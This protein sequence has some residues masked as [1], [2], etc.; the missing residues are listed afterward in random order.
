MK[1]ARYGWIR[2]LPDPRDAVLSDP[3]P[4]DGS[5]G[6]SVDLRAD[7][8]AA[9]DQGDLAACTANALASL[10]EFRSPLTGRLLEWMPSR[11]FLYY[12]ERAQA[13]TAGAD[14]G[15]PIRDG[16]KATLRYGACSDTDW[17]YDPTRYS[18]RPPAKLYRTSD[19]L[20]SLRYARVP[21][22][23]LQ[24]KA[25]LARHI[26]FVLGMSIFGNMETDHVSKSGLIPLPRP[27]DP[28]LGGHVVTVVGYDDRH[29]Y[30]IVR[31]SWG[32]GWGDH[33]YGYLPYAYA[34]DSGLCADGWALVPTPSTDPAHT[35]ASH[36][37]AR[38]E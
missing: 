37:V 7:F 20:Q 8:P 12:N 29:Q 9:Y 13:G 10:L 22:T 33:G 5:V 16:I 26:P 6:T 24:M 18:R 35:S 1:I 14:C 15:S 3:V 17:P 36:P 28:L 30:F 25:I 11:L 19:L 32:A 34:L 21:Q 23:I 38:P 31:N 27:T 4:L 2:D